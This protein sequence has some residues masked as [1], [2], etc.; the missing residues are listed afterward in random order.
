MQDK[1]RFLPLIKRDK[2][3]EIV[4]KDKTPF[5]RIK[6]VD[7]Y[8]KNEIIMG[9]L[10]QR[11]P[12]YS[13]FFHIILKHSP[14]KLSE[15]DKTLGLVGQKAQYVFLSYSFD[16]SKQFKSFHSYFNEISCK[17]KLVFNII[18]SFKYLL[19]SV[20]IL[21]SHKIVHFSFTPENIVFDSLDKPYLTNFSHSF[22]FENLNEERKSNLFSE[23]RENSLFLPL[24]AK[25]CLLL[26]NHQGSLSK[27]N[28]EQ[29]C[30]DF[31]GKLSEIMGFID[32]EYLANNLEKCKETMKDCLQPIINKS[33]EEVTKGLL[34]TCS[35]NWDIY[36][37]FLTYLFLTRDLLENGFSCN[38]L[39]DFSLLL[40]KFI[41]HCCSKRENID[42]LVFMQKFDQM[43]E[44]CDF[45]D[46]AL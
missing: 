32:N 9:N 19:K 40:V 28:I 39:D 12:D 29:L 27:S 13:N 46:I 4:K 33:K 31:F 35:C 44:K 1:M 36:S 34:S 37:L 17:R 16:S 41:I 30:D 14:V 20:E 3:V 26:N 15:V 45:D 2:K 24:F 7:F 18:N 42:F 8:S 22:H 10:V 21:A 43:I 38:F 25:V 6:T 11:I 5:S 23:I